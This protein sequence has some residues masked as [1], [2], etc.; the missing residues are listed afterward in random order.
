[1]KKILLSFFLIFIS[2]SIFSQGTSKGD[3]REN[4]VQ[5]N[6]LIL[7]QNYSLALKYFKDAYQI[8]SSNANINYKV[9]FCY[10]ESA[11][12]KNKALTYLEK[13]VQNVGHNYNPEDPKEKKAPELAYYSLAVAYRLAYR[14]P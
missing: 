4:F 10:L 5:G 3:Y 8:D 6:Y 13:A 7:E 1:M 9:G 2:A 12:E 14:F 11:T